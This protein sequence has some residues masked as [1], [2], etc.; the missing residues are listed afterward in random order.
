MAVL[1]KQEILLLVVGGVFV[2]E[3]GSV[4][5]QVGYYKITRLLTGTPKRLFLCAPFHH[6]LQR[7]G[8]T[9]TQIVVR[10]WIMAIVLAALGLASLKVR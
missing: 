3:A 8:W 10:F 4:I 2:M 9:E 5:L 7:L 6:H 1:V